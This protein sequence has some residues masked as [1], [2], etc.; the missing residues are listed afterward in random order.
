M[1]QL[2]KIHSYTVYFWSNEGDPLE[3]VHVHIAEGQPVPNGTKVWL[4]ADGSCK[5]DGES[6]IEQHKL[7]KILEVINS[8]RSYIISKWK[9]RFGNAELK[10]Q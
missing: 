4:M 2:F 1:P 7:N 3:P 10:Q 6:S 8:N 5:V 9:T